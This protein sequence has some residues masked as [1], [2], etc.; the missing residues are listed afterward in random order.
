MKEYNKIILYNPYT[1]CVQNVEFATNFHIFEIAGK[2]DD[3]FY[4]FKNNQTNKNN[5]IQNLLYLN[6][7]KYM[8]DKDYTADMLSLNGMLDFEYNSIIIEKGCPNGI[9]KKLKEWFKISDDVEITMT[10]MTFNEMMF[11][12]LAKYRGEL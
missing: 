2:C 9:V 8:Y 1:S 7:A 10:T 12:E 5:K 4:Y 6:W 11:N 3:M